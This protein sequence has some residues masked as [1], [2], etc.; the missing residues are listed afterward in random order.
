MKIT[1]RVHSGE[2]PF[3]CTDW[4]YLLLKCVVVIAKIHSEKH[5]SVLIEMIFVY[6]SHI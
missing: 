3:S 1:C 4:S 5:S 6:Q 2:K